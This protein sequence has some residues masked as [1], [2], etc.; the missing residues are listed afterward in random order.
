MGSFCH[1]VF[2]F[3]TRHCYERW[4]SKHPDTVPF[5][6]DQ[7]FVLAQRLNTRNFGRA[8]AAGKPYETAIAAGV[9]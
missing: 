7:A 1:F 4:A 8:F 5:S 2:F 3:A 9:V 6:L